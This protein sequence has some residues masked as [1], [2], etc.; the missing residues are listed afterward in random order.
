MPY[1][2]KKTNPKNPQ[3][4]QQT[5]QKIQTKPQACDMQQKQE[6]INNC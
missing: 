4:Q 6:S 1:L 2:E 3:Q 5:S